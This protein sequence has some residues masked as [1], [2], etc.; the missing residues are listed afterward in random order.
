MTL[1][2]FFEYLI[3]RLELVLFIDF[4]DHAVPKQVPHRYFARSKLIL[5]VSLNKYMYDS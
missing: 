3:H 2:T 4:T 1:D 5:E